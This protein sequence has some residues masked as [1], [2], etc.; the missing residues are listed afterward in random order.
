MNPTT[1]RCAIE[2]EGRAIMIRKC[3]LC[4]AAPALLQA[5]RAT[6]SLLGVILTERRV[7]V[8]EELETVCQKAIEQ[9]EA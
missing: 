7:A 2:T 8:V 5:A 3:P 1:C 9:A 4:Q 6:R